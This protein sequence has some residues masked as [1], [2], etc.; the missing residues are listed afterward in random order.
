LR[1]RFRIN[2][3]SGTVHGR[4]MIAMG[5]EIPTC[6]LVDILDAQDDLVGT[7]YEPL[8]VTATM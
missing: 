3:G 8:K 4:W 7:V 5:Q 2:G 1:R 6:G